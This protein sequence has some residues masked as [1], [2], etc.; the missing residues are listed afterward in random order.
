LAAA[1][2]HFAD[3]DGTGVNANTDLERT[4]EAHLQGM[5]GLDNPEPDPHGPC[6]IIFMGRRIAEVHEEPITEVLSDMAVK[7]LDYLR[8]GLLIRPNYLAEFFGIQ[9]SR[10]GS[11]AHQ[12]TEQHGELAAFGLSSRRSRR[13]KGS[14]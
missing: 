5:H 10:E 11:G 6:G 13:R 12:V 9:L 2:A 7:A 14:I 3:D 1:S 4:R 8:T